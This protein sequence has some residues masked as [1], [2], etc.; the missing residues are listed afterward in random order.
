MNKNEEL[1][2]KVDVGQ[3]IMQRATLCIHFLTNLTQL[4]YRPGTY[5]DE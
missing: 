2:P 1:Q 5:T 3:T 4:Y